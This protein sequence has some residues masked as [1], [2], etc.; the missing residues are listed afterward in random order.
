M[1]AKHLDRKFDSGHDITRHLDT[2]RHRRPNQ[3]K[4]RVSLTLPLWM[5]HALDKQAHRLNVSR[6]SL[7]KI[8]IAERLE[9][10]TTDLTAAPPSESD[11]R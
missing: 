11:G 10:T 3:Q 2:P 7:I 4:K 1:K 5:L 6:Q 9:R 8:Y